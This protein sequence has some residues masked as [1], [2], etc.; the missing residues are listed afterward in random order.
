M[1]HGDVEK[2]EGIANC[3]MDRKFAKMTTMLAAAVHET[4]KLLWD[5]RPFCSGLFCQSRKST[6]VTH[7]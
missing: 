7:N 2:M 1:C 5:C 6:G 3:K 4:E